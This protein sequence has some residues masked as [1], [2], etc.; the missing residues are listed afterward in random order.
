MVSVKTPTELN[1]CGGLTLPLLRVRG[2]PGV[3]YNAGWSE[4]FRWFNCAGALGTVTSSET[5]LLQSRHRLNLI[6]AAASTVNHLLLSTAASVPV[7]DFRGAVES[8]DAVRGYLLSLGT[9][10]S[11]V[12]LLRVR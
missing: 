8:S 4:L 5:S 7:L 12:P 2:R 1:H 6:I 10:F 3:N 9:V 11:T